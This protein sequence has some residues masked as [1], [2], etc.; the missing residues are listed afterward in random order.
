MCEDVEIRAEDETLQFLMA[1]AKGRVGGEIKDPCSL[2]ILDE[3]KFESYDEMCLSL[4][5]ALFN[6]IMVESV[7]LGIEQAKDEHD[8]KD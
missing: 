7:Q 6:S 8:T 1:I 3:C 5:R 2:S 4:G